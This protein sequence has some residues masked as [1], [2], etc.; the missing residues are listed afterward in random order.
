[1]LYNILHIINIIQRQTWHKHGFSDVRGCA[2]NYEK[3]HTKLWPCVFASQHMCKQSHLG[4]TALIQTIHLHKWS[5]YSNLTCDI[6]NPEKLSPTHTHITLLY[7]ALWM[8]EIA[9]YTDITTIW[10]YLKKSERLKSMKWKATS[11]SKLDFSKTSLMSTKSQILS[12]NSDFMAGWYRGLLNE[13]VHSGSLWRAD[14]PQKGSN[15]VRTTLFQVTLKIRS[16][17]L[18][19]R[20]RGQKQD[21]HHLKN[22]WMKSSI[23]IVSI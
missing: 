10:N 9:I 7:G 3:C 17:P 13:G 18:K 23:Q 20:S 1:M 16:Q 15:M 19:L 21:V 11:I 5:L 12:P 6:H 2:I 4:W 22:D 8:L 14:K